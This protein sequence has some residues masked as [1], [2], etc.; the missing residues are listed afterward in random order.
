MIAAVTIVA[1][2]NAGANEIKGL[3][4]AEL[5]FELFPKVGL[6]FDGYWKFGGLIH[7]TMKKHAKYAT[8]SLQLALIG[9]PTT[10]LRVR[11]SGSTQNLWAMDLTLS[12]P[13]IS[14]VTRN[15]AT[16]CSVNPMRFSQSCIT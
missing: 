10:N 6:L 3:T 15:S 11:T 12:S 16:N 9:W 14:G 13:M 1:V 8:N 5:V 2:R 7:I 4:S